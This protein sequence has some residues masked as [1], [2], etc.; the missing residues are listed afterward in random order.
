MALNHFTNHGTKDEVQLQMPGMPAASNPLTQVSYGRVKAGQIVSYIG[1]LS[2]GPQCGSS[3]VVRQIFPKH[4][5]VD[6]GNKNI[7][8]I[9]YCFLNI[10]SQ[11]A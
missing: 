2:G 10:T 4:A 8:H 11:A 9:P 5:V 3:G 1:N 7:W 6:L